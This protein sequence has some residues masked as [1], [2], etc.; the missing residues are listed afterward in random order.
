MIA[1]GWRPR[2]RGEGLRIGST[3]RVASAAFLARD[4]DALFVAQAVERGANLVRAAAEQ[5]ADVLQS[6]HG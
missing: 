2:A 1:G 3:H 5:R 4:T 6:S